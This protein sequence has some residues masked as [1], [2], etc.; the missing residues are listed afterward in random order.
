MRWSTSARLVVH[1][2]DRVVQAV[3]VGALGDEHVRAVGD[4]GV[5]QDRHVAAAEVAGEHEP[6]SAALVVDVEHDDGAAQHVAGVEEGQ[7]RRPARRWCGGGRATATMLAERADHVVLV[8]ERL[9]RLHVEVLALDQLVDVPR[10]GSWIIA[11]S[12][13]IAA[14]RSR[15]AGV[16]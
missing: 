6:R 14:Q 3:A 12:A 1:P 9:D 16:A 15:V 5:A 4:L 13:S 10:V 2:L 7:R 8:V 11:E